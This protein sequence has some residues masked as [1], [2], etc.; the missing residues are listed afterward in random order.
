MIPILGRIHS[1]RPNFQSIARGRVLSESSP[2]IIGLFC[3]SGKPDDI[4]GF[5]KS[6]IDELI[7]IS[8]ETKDA[9]LIA[10]RLCTASLRCVISDSPMR[11]YLK[12]SKGHTG[13]WA[14]DRCIQKGV[15]FK[16][17]AKN[18]VL[19]DIA[20]PLRKDKDFLKYHVN[21][22]SQDDHLD[23]TKE[24]PFV[25]LNFDRVTGFV[26][27]PMHTFEE[28]SFGRRLEG[29]ASV[30]N[31]GKISKEALTEVNQRIAAFKFW[32]VN[33]FD[34]SVEDFSKCGSYKMHVKRQFL[35][36][37]LFPV[38]EGI[39]SD[40]ELEHIMMLQYA[41]LLLGT[42]DPQPV[43]DSNIKLARKVLNFYCVELTERDIPC[44][45][46]SHQTIHIPDDVAKYQ[47]GVETLS[48][49]Q[50]E[51]FLSFFRRCLRS[52]N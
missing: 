41:M 33:D 24:S 35:Y 51:S 1:I 5:L 22:I 16:G 20:A 11:A 32:K 52:G 40:S 18:I 10:N 46:V 8:P 34:R 2:F 4:D 30:P 19:E 28:G 21:D 39:L 47:C 26:I 50:Y 49:Y 12:R 14:C 44:R 45:F 6:T 36:Y 31:E 15:G 7:R 38:F 25:R 9:K 29:F 3:G 23:P 17:N 43:S 13:Y 27:E 48:A 42:F 37:H